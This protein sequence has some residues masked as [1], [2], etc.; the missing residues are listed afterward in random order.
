[1]EVT[2]MA[3]PRGHVPIRVFLRPEHL[4]DN[5]DPTQL[6]AFLDDRRTV[7]MN[8]LQLCRKMF[9][10]L[11]K[12]VSSFREILDDLEDLKDEFDEDVVP[13]VDRMMILGKIPLVRSRFNLKQKSELWE[14]IKD[15]VARQAPRV[16]ELQKRWAVGYMAQ[17][18]GLTE[19]MARL[20]V[21][22][23]HP[24]NGITTW[25]DWL[26]LTVRNAQATV[27]MSGAIGATTM[28]LWDAIYWWNEF[29]KNVFL[30]GAYPTKQVL[31][32]VKADYAVLNGAFEAFV[33]AMEDVSL[34]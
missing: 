15:N 31:Q 18:G 17:H 14:M 9:R 6:R 1:M 34:S 16:R 13:K 24:M 4:D 19:I 32:A 28:M 23:R 30:E 3:V 10:D 22:A 8:Q 25:G 27:A 12:T 29:Q 26:N 20:E 7:A 2:T 21:E 11:Q 33:W 5:S